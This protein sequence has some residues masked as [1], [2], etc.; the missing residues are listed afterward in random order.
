MKLNQNIFLV[1][2]F[3]S[4]ANNSFAAGFATNSESASGLANSYAGQ[5]TGVHDISDSYT[6]PAILSDI[7][8]KQFVISAT[9]ITFDVD[10][11]KIMVVANF[12]IIAQ[13]LLPEMI[14]A[15]LMR[16]CRL[17]IL[18]RQLIKN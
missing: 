1:L 5:A 15:E 7:K 13:F 12:L 11:D 16:L 18:L 4:T 17:C 9:Y 10:D 8:S 2:F 14:M 3:I 6:N